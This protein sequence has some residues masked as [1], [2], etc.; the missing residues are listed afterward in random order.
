LLKLVIQANLVTS[1]RITTEPELAR[2]VSSIAPTTSEGAMGAMQ[3]A[4]LLGAT[5]N[6]QPIQ[7]K[8]LAV[9]TFGNSCPIRQL[10]IQLRLPQESGA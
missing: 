1:H 7:P 8:Q 2:G 4:N 10:F 6:F 3:T 9:V 5:L